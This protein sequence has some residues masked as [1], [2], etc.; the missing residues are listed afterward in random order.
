[1]TQSPSFPLIYLERLNPPE[2]RTSY[3]EAL[4]IAI[5]LP[6]WIMERYESILRSLAMH[7]LLD[8]EVCYL[9]CTSKKITGI[10]YQKIYHQD[11]KVIL[12]V[13]EYWHTKNLTITTDNAI[14]D[15]LQADAKS[16]S[17]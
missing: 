17:S 1:M 6:R 12:Y 16:C 5:P 14:D 15:L 2:A 13:P 7:M 3:Q 10:V 8:I 4:I 9:S 11:R